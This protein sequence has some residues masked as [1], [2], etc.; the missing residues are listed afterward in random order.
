MLV[1]FFGIYTSKYLCV[2]H[3][4]D[5]NIK[6]RKKINDPALIVVNQVIERGDTGLPVNRAQ[7]FKVFMFKNSNIMASAFGK[8][9]LN[10]F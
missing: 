6:G 8:Q 1:I 3:P 5:L 4:D 9:K 2:I 10:L 7:R